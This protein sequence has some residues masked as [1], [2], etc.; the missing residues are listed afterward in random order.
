MQKHEGLFCSATKVSGTEYARTLDAWL[1]LMYAE[2]TE[3]EKILADGET[4]AVGRAR[5]QEGRGKLFDY[6]FCGC[7]GTLNP[8]P[9]MFRSGACFTSCAR[10]PL[11]FAMGASG[12]SATTSSREGCS[13]LE[14]IGQGLG[15]RV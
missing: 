11:G 14:D 10:K 3:C 5:F 6:E 13:V 15:L 8:K 7:G 4:A 1:H 9:L 12:W 2:R